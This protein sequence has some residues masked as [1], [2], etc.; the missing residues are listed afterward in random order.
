MLNQKLKSKSG[1]KKAQFYKGTIQ[2]KA[3]TNPKDLSLKSIKFKEN[4]NEIP[5]LLS[6]KP[7]V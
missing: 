5:S 2:R 6:G 7:V 1:A 4:P 3:Q